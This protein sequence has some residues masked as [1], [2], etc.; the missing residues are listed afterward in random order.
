MRIQS[1]EFGPEREETK[2]VLIDKEALTAHVF[3]EV[4]EVAAFHGDVEGDENADPSN[5]S[6]GCRPLL[7][8][9][10]NANWIAVSCDF[11]ASFFYYSPSG[12]SSSCYSQYM[13]LTLNEADGKIASM[14]WLPGTSAIVV[15]TTE[16]KMMIVD[17]ATKA[18]LYKTI[19][20]IQ[21][22]APFLSVKELLDSLELWLVND[23]GEWMKWTVNIEA[24]NKS[25]ELK[26]QDMVQAA[27]N[28]I[29]ASTC[30]TRFVDVLNGLFFFFGLSSDGRIWVI[31]PETRISYQMEFKDRCIRLHEYCNGRYLLCL[32]ESGN[33]YVF[34]QAT[35][36]PIFIRSITKPEKAEKIV[37]F[38]CT[39]NPNF[40][41]EF[42]TLVLTSEADAHRLEVRSFPSEQTTYSARTTRATQIFVS[43]DQTSNM[44][45]MLEIDEEYGQTVNLRELTEM[46]PEKRL[47]KLISKRRFDEAEAFAKQFG[48]D[49]QKIYTRRIYCL[50]EDIELA[51]TAQEKTIIMAKLV[52]AFQQLS[53]DNLIGDLCFSVAV[54]IGNGDMIAQLLEISKKRNVTDSETTDR[55]SSLGYMFTSYRMIFG[56][57]ASYDDVSYWK[58]FIE[59]ISSKDVWPKIFESLISKEM[60]HESRVLW[61]RHQ[62]AIISFYA[63][64]EKGFE[65]ISDLFIIFQQVLLLNL[66]RWQ[67]VVDF[68][69]EDLMIALIQNDSF[70]AFEEFS[71]LMK[72]LMS[73]LE[74]NEGNNFPDNSL[75]VALS[76][77]RMLRNVTQTTISPSRQAALGFYA[78]SL[79]KSEAKAAIEEMATCAIN[80]TAIKR[81]KEVYNYEIGYKEFAVG[82]K[83]TRQRMNG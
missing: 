19:T 17:A 52:S 4:K 34:E 57:A 12:S 9:A 24:V 5:P 26:E 63:D 61:H 31:E 55:L 13:R 83:R 47:E 80:L 21:T 37:D 73:D 45:F 22:D 16:K 72:N 1:V 62:K 18:V 35:M 40:L 29:E 7:H 44:L 33:M 38:V 70:E 39:E 28:F 60:I 32:T 81:L 25:V 78:A 56:P 76:F 42:S 27:G 53:D 58:L 82:V 6:A 49:L 54:T 3:F 50:V 65:R 23:A 14:C 20:A 66:S 46:Q 2:T 77:E 8:S 10:T 30:P 43:A 69:V 79:K 74:V 41:G 64:A 71:H 51:D 11:D 68:L 36:T 75:H 15:V 67:Q 48:L 59:G